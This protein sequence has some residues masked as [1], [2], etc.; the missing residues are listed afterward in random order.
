MSLPHPRKAADCAPE[1]DQVRYNRQLLN[2]MLT[3]IVTDPLRGQ[4]KNNVVIAVTKELC[5]KK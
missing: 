2:L 5:T 3:R 1:N 4:I